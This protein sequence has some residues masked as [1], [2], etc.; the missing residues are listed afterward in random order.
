MEDESQRLIED[1]LPLDMIGEQAARRHTQHSGNLTALHIWWGR[2]PQVAARAAVYATLV[3]APHDHTQRVAY[4]KMLA[5]LCEGSVPPSVLQQAQRQIAEVHRERSRS[6]GAAATA[7]P[8]IVDLFAGGGTIALEAARLGCSALAGDL[9]PVAFLIEQCGL[10]Y[11]QRHP[12]LASH[13]TTWGQRLIAAARDATYTAYETRPNPVAASSQ[14]TLFAA[15]STQLNTPPA[16]TQPDVY[17]WTR[18]VACPNPGCGA[19]VPLAPSTRLVEKPGRAIALRI[20]PSTDRRSVRFLR[21]EATS[22]AGF[23]FPTENLSARGNARCV[24]CGATVPSA[25]VKAEGSAGRMGKQLMA[26]ICR[27]ADRSRHYIAADDLPYQW[28]LPDEA[29]QQRI[30]QLCERSGLTPPNEPIYDRDTR[31]FTTHSYG[32]R[33]FADHFTPRQLF[34]LLTC[35][36]QLRLMHQ[37]MQQEGMD[38]ELATAITSYLA[39]LVNR[40]VDSCSSMCRWIPSSESV[41]NSFS[42]Q[43]VQVA[44][45]FAE[46]NPFGTGWA[47]ATDALDRMTETISQLSRVAHPGVVQRGPAHQSGLPNNSV[48]ALITDPP[49]YDSVP[50]ADLSDF[51]YVWLKRSI[52][53]LYPEHFAGELT[54]KKWEAYANPSRHNGSKREANLSYQAIIQR[55]LEEAHRILKPSA[56]LVLIYAHTTTAGWSSIV[57]AMRLAGFVVTEAWPLTTESR[58]RIR[59]QNS[60]AL[61]SSI[62]IV[63]RKR[64]NT[65]IGNYTR[66]V[67]PE[68][69]ATVRERVDTLTAFGIGGAD[70]V[71]ATVGAGLRAYTRFARV[72]RDNGDELSA[73]SFLEEVQ[74]AALTAILAHVVGMEASGVEAVDAVSQYYVLARYQYGTAEV[75]FDQANVLARGIGVEMAGAASLTSGANPLLAKAKKKVQLRDYRQRGAAHELGTNGEQPAPL[76]DVLHRLLWLNDHQP[77]AIPIFLAAARPD[78]ARLWLV[79]EALGGPRLISQ[80]AP[81]VARDDRTDEQRAIG[82]LLPVWRR[83]VEQSQPPINQLSFNEE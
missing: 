49:Y 66:D 32:M 65:S 11:P 4:N 63:A 6:E 76:I 8:L 51:F 16:I 69:Q 42:R 13:V 72:E 20:E 35:V 64:T 60:A 81:G 17:L 58:G 29:M 82:R 79:A 53:Q 48:D 36:E 73:S 5:A 23:D 56:P 12:H 50:Y 67:L 28:L 3:A 80:P 15:A 39:L 78:L 9:N 68:L 26:V 7:Q 40:M 70:L 55:S 38:H 34:V 24:C 25:H 14:H 1:F 54:P 59:A 19:S 71:I 27:N 22:V 31:A 37:Q 44:W 18:T 2:K 41:A 10:V 75:D 62:F 46:I 52:G 47:N 74:R 77:S 61:S 43:A 57:D 45:S 83:V 33:R 21:A 30:D